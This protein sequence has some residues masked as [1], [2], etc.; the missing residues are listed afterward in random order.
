[1]LRDSIQDFALATAKKHSH[2]CVQARHVIYAIVKITKLE[3]LEG[4][5]ESIAPN[6]LE[7]PGDSLITQGPDAEAAKLLSDC[8]THTSATLLAWRWLHA[9][10][11]QQKG[12]AAAADTANKAVTPPR[13]GPETPEEVLA[14][15][16]KLVGLA[17]VK[18]QLREVLAVVLANAARRQAGL[19]EVSSS[20]HL[21]FSGSPGTGKTTVARIVARMY[22]A[23]G[24]IGGSKF[25]EVH[26]ANL[27]G[28]YVGKT[29]IKTLEVIA[30]ARPGVLFIDEAY[31]LVAGHDQDY[32]R[33][34]IATLVKAMED[35]RSEL[36]V[37]A[38][39]YTVE[40]QKFVDVNP[41]LRSRFKTFVEFPDYTPKELA[42]VFASFA[43]ASKIE[44]AEGVLRRVEEV[45]AAAAK[46]PDFGNARFARSLWE[47][48][49]A[50]MA[51]RAHADGE[52][53]LR[54]V[55]ELKTEDIPPYTPPSGWGPE[56]KIGFWA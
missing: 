19:P 14:D 12:D 53:E 5:L 43:A 48:S 18:K 10:E 54:E 55:L 30:S 32:G 39:G 34:A 29:A 36:A 38:A 9:Y 27:V 52:I 44:L 40:M 37:I 15:L 46:A 20:L 7:P 16:D 23:C 26:R 4:V 24:A 17:P 2:P 22:A 35:H 56:G 41:G 21:V 3:P 11:R 47:R 31:S 50:N 8:K 45:I 13:R 28:E 51:V 1:M 49:F 33:E 6:L 42:V 25:V